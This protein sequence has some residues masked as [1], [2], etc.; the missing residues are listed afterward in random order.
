MK[1]RRWIN[2]LVKHQEGNATMIGTVVTMLIGCMMVGPLLSFMASG[3]ESGRVYEN[4][5]Y[6][7]YASDAGVNYGIWTVEKAVG[8]PDVGDDPLEHNIPDIN[9]KTVN[10]SITRVDE[11]TFKITGTATSVDGSNTVI[12]SY[13]NTLDFA[14]LLDNGLTSGGDVTMQPNSTVDG[15]VQYNGIL[16]QQ[17]GADITGEF[18]TD[19]IASWPTQEQ[20]SKFY[21]TDVSGST[22]FPYPDAT[23]NAAAVDTVDALYRDGNLTISTTNPNQSLALNGTM[24]VTGD[25]TCEATGK[26]YTLDLNGQTIYSEGAMVF[27]PSGLWLTGSGCIIA[28]G[29]INFSPN[30]QT[31]P[32]DFVFIMSLTGNVIMQPTNEFHGCV[33]GDA[34]VDLFP[35]T[36]VYWHEPPDILNLPGKLNRNVIEGIQTWDITSN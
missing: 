5:T 35:N 22:P 3:I 21:W 31:D 2:N 15:D 27:Q 7:L 33:A 10:I 20:L 11:N 25:F 30:L 24:F 8:L 14:A 19:P 9:G 17:P 29:D 28:V 23:I 4:L 6:E 36:D 16:D 12:E 26:K 13:V 18:D 32:D 1:M 34:G